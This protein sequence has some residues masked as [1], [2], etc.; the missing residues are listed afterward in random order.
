[1]VGVL[2]AKRFGTGYLTVTAS[3]WPEFG[4]VTSDITFSWQDC[5]SKLVFWA[6]FTVLTV[7]G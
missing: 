6:N 7:T 2:L 5:P 4:A 3:L 1:M